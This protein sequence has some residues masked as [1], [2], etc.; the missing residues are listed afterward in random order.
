MLLFVMAQLELGKFSLVSI[1]LEL[2]QTFQKDAQRIAAA[3][4]DL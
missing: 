1:A 2:I 4:I 3:I